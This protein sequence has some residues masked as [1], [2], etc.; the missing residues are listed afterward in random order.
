MQRCRLTSPAINSMTSSTSKSMAVT[1]PFRQRRG[2]CPPRAQRNIACCKPLQ[3]GTVTLEI[4]RHLE[5]G[6]T[7]VSTSRAAGG[8]RP[9]RSGC[10]KP[11]TPVKYQRRQGLITPPAGRPIPR[12]AYQDALRRASAEPAGVTSPASARAVSTDQPFCENA[13]LIRSR[14]LNIQIGGSVRA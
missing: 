2:G 3:V 1:S 13:T 5:S 8:Q 14:P 12:P 7:V 4:A 6:T 10:P 11:N 9:C